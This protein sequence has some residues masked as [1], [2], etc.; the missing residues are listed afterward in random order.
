MATYTE[1]LNAL[2]NPFIKT[3]RLR[4]LQ[5]DGSTAF[6]V[7]N[8]YLNKRN[9]TFISSG[10]LT[11]NLQ[12]GQRRSAGI[13]LDNVNSDFDYSVNKLWFGTEIALDE[14]LVLPDGDVYYIQQ[15]VFLL[16]NPQET[17]A[18]SGRTMNYSLVDK[19]ANLDGRMYGYLDSS[20]LVQEGTNIF[21]A[22]SS[23]LSL[24]K[25][26]QR[27]VDAV[28]PIFTT[29]YNNKT[30]RL[31]DGT[32]AYYTDA[33]YDLTVEAGNTFADVITGLCEMLAA[34]VGYDSTGALRVDASQDDISDATKPIAWTFSQDETQLLGLSYTIHNSE[35][36]ND[37]QIVGDQLDD[38]TQPVARARNYDPRSDTNIN[39][40][41]RKTLREEKSGFSTQTQ[42][43]DYAVWKLKRVT[44]LQKSVQISSTQILHIQENQLVEIVRTDKPGSPVERHLIQGFSRPLAG[45]GNMTIDAVSVDDFPDITVTT[46]SHD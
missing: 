21:T 38:Y 7:D 16:D 39:I 46:I 17:I 15:G 40:I 9:K 28:H 45:T 37:I 31:A 41:G 6:A 1:Y 10:S 30:I 12:N 42:C 43:V 8:N 3:C 32:T 20:Y 44:A 25:Y 23:I 27:V 22:I 29:Y 2:R 13:T 24:S 33:P 26:N 34:W 35:V 19:W 4:F 5:P 11:V 36:F 18:P 14:G